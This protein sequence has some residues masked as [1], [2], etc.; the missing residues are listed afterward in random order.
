MG[1]PNS[2]KPFQSRNRKCD[3]PAPGP[4]GADCPGNLIEH[5][6][7]LPTLPSESQKSYKWQKGAVNMD[8]IQTQRHS[9]L[10]YQPIE[11][12]L[13]SIFL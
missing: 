2:A 13:N 12:I 8:L 4:G 9:E 6:E 3:R 1:L 5:G 7:P 10:Q 11:N